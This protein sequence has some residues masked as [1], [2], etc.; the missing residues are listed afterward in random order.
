MPTL[1]LVT[2]AIEAPTGLILLAV[3]S[4]VTSLLF[5][6]PLE[7]PVG[8]VIARI[9]G[10]ALIA[11]ALTCWFARNDMQS[12]AARGLIKVLL[13]YNVVVMLVL[14]HAH[15]ALALAGLAL[16]PAVV[17]HAILAGWC[18]QAKAPSA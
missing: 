14:L 7:A 6:A 9:A 18:I 4:L 3:P 13:F 15:F 11:L 8:T 5:A 10:A 1:L 2:A 12:R 17:V 16:W